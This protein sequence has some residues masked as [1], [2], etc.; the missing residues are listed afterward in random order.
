VESKKIQQT[1]EYNKNETNSQIQKTNYKLMV[2][3]GERDSGEE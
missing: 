2:T 1:S 3:S